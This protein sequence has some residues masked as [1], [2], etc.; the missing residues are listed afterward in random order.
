[1]TRSIGPWGVRPSEE[2]AEYTAHIKQAG[3]D[4]DGNLVVTGSMDHPV[5]DHGHFPLISAQ[6]L[7]ISRVRGMRIVRCR[8]WREASGFLG[9]EEL[10]S[11][12]HIPQA[13]ETIINRALFSG[14]K[15]PLVASLEYQDGLLADS[16][17]RAQTLTQPLSGWT[18]RIEEKEGA[19]SVVISAFLHASYLEDW[20]T[21]R[22]NYWKNAP[23]QSRITLSFEVDPI[24]RIACFG[25]YVP[26]LIR[27]SE[28]LPVAPPR[29]TL[30]ALNIE[31]ATVGVF[32]AFAVDGDRWVNFHERD[33]ENRGISITE[34]GPPT[35][36]AEGFLNDSRDYRWPRVSLYGIDLGLISSQMIRSRAYRMIF[37]N[38]HFG[39]LTYH[40]EEPSEEITEAEIEVKL[41]QKGLELF[42]Q[43][44]GPAIKPGQF[45]LPWELLILRYPAF[46]RFRH[47]TFF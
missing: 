16:T 39:A 11:E 37:S 17:S 8:A 4:L 19:I 43:L 25:S 24:T 26:S 5:D 13:L 12:L 29:S 38:G 35:R 23:A 27:E 10:G 30:A 18:L 9:V 14:V 22:S 21:S 34:H 46:C 6:W 36:T 1:M 32:T 42:Y 47:T 20:N 45:T 41:T 44:R 7:R 28:G 3:V 2:R 15:A 33:H 31:N 40:R